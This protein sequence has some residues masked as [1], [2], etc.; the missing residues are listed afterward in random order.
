MNPFRSGCLRRFV[1]GTRKRKANL[2]ARLDAFLP[3]VEALEHRIVLDDSSAAAV[4]GI[5]ARGLTTLGGV[6]LTGKDIRI[7]Q[8]E[9][10]RPGKPG[11]DNPANSHPDVT[12]SGVYLRGGNP[13]ANQNTTGDRGH[14]TQVAGVMIADGVTNKGIST[15]AS[16]Y[17]SAAMPQG[18]Q[19]DVYAQF[20]SAVQQ[21]ALQSPRAVNM[22]FWNGGNADGNSLLSLG[23]DWS[24]KKYDILNVMSRG[25]VGEPGI[26]PKDSYNGVAVA[27]SE[28]V[29]TAGQ[30]VY[31]KI[32]GAN[33]FTN[34]SNNR[35]L[36]AR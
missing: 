13:V 21:V 14:A 20:M 32:A 2:V 22:S 8:V 30:Q 27:E 24:A 29:L 18:K 7:G 19:E 33:N 4:T 9:L 12:P 10:F 16:L 15:G 5:D 6:V 23:V 17:A 28:T 25:N 31:R 34:D 26:V 3:S 1:S 35:R 36:T 11:F